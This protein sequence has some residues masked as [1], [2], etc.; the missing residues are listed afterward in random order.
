MRGDQNNDKENKGFYN[1]NRMP[2]IIVQDDENESD[3][4]YIQSEDENPNNHWYQ[5]D[6]ELNTNSIKQDTVIM[7]ESE[8]YYE[9]ADNQNSP[10]Q[11]YKYFKENDWLDYKC[12]P[13]NKEKYVNVNRINQRIEEEWDNLSASESSEFYHNSPTFREQNNVDNKKSNNLIKYTLNDP[14]NFM[15]TSQILSK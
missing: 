8:E 9:S 7:N 3:S 1:S 12:F 5:A 6:E 10:Q 15:S 4:D 13:D 14:Q 11:N 2:T